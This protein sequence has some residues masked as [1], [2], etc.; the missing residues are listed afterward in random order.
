MFPDS[1]IELYSVGI[2]IKYYKAETIINY[3]KIF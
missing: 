1:S 3:D 2:L